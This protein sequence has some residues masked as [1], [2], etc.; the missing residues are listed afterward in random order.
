MQIQTSSRKLE[1][2]GE[3]GQNKRGYAFPQSFSHLMRKCKVK[4]VS[5]ET[6]R[7]WF[8]GSQ[9][10]AWASKRAKRLKQGGVMPGTR[11][12]QC[13]ES[14]SGA[15]A[16]WAPRP[17]LSLT[18]LPW[19]SSPPEREQH[20]M[21]AMLLPWFELCTSTYMEQFF[22]HRERGREGGRDGEKH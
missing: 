8:G 20:N 13:Q 12:K 10:W 22:F 21:L 15:S 1:F 3:K 14:V 18:R 9:T 11:E 7:M 17:P 6:S 4:F 19:A 5:L 2:R 16:P